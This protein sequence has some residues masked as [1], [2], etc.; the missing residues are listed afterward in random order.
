[1]LYNE[2]IYKY[3]NNKKI[4]AIDYL[5]LITLKSMLKSGLFF[6]YPESEKILHE[7]NLEIMGRSETEN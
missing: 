2:G 6:T 7:V 5:D 3:L 4:E 1:M